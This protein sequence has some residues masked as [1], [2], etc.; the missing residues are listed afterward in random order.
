M[1]SRGTR[2]ANP[3][4]IR[5]LK[6]W[7]SRWPK[8]ENLAFD[9]EERNPVVFK[10]GGVDRVKEI[11]WKREGDTLIMLT[12]RD[13]FRKSAIDAAERRMNKYRE[14][15]Q[16]A[17]NA[18]TEDLQSAEAAVLEAWRKYH[19][20]ATI[21]GGRAE[22]MREIIEAEKNLQ[23]LSARLT[24]SIERKAVELDGGKF[25]TI[26]TAPFPRA[27]RGIDIATLDA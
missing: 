11:P 13:G 1:T 3:E 8:A 14:D 10:K 4:L 25:R 20:A 15:R 27:L 18:A 7:V 12:Q 9:K 26:H 24:N 19:L 5:T 22:L 2:T 17:I 23:A 16:T 21:P 6:D